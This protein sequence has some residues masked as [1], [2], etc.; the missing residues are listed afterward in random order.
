[1]LPDMGFH[2]EPFEHLGT[3][4]NDFVEKVKRPQFMTAGAFLMVE[5]ER[6]PLRIVTVSAL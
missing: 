2:P 1:M 6:D 5:G 4:S 3:L